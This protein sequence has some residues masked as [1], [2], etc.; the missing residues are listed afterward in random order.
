[1]SLLDKIKSESEAGGRGKKTKCY[2]FRHFPELSEA[3]QAELVA[4]LRDVEVSDA[5]I[6]R[7]LSEA[8]KE[9]VSRSTIQRH[10]AHDCSCTGDF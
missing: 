7:A 9:K 8:F 3:D 2:I 4:A 1:M 5:A 10:R 6:A